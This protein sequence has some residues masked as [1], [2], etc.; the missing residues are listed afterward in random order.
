MTDLIDR[1][2]AFLRRAA[3]RSAHVWVDR[4][5]GNVYITGR[6]AVVDSLT[7]ELNAVAPALRA[8]ETAVS[9]VEK[10]LRETRNTRPV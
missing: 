8:K 1:S 3:A 5:N 6:P 2:E 9:L 4:S 7:D 10:L